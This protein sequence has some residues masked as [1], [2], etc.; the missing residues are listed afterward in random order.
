MSLS[1]TCCTYS[2]ILSFHIK[3]IK[4]F[5]EA[6]A[7]ELLDCV[8]NI[9]EGRKKRILELLDLPNLSNKSIILI[10][11]NGKVKSLRKGICS[12]KKKVTR[13]KFNDVSP[14]Q[15]AALC[16]DFF[17]VHLFIKKLPDHQKYAAW[18]QLEAIRRRKDY[19]A[20]FFALQKAYH[21]YLKRWNAQNKKKDRLS[22]WVTIWDEPEYLWEE[23]GEHQKKLSIFGLQVLC[24]PIPYGQLP[25]LTQEP[26]R[27]L[28]VDHDNEL[29]LD[30]IGIGTESALSKG[31]SRGARP[32]I[33]W[34]GGAWNI[35]E[36]AKEWDMVCEVVQNELDKARKLL[37]SYTHAETRKQF[38][39]VC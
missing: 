36:N 18:L 23:V 21:D 14:L 3:T 26:I 17:L 19:L 29:N 2:D 22:F 10:H 34:Q 8:L 37:L 1:Q 38:V 30:S 20:A 32:E 27:S 6:R 15:A 11:S 39:G 35:E 7:S 25:N 13:M 4:K 31:Y 5:A 24:N 12:K 9:D 28:L 33:Y 16:G